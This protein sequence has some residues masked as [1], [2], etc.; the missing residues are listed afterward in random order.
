MVFQFS[1]FRRSLKFLSSDKQRSFF[2]S[3]KQRGWTKSWCW[4]MTNDWKLSWSN[5]FVIFLN[6]IFWWW[7]FLCHSLSNLQTVVKKTLYECYFAPEKTAFYTSIILYMVPNDHSRLQAWQSGKTTHEIFRCQKSNIESDSIYSYIQTVVGLRKKRKP[8]SEIQHRHFHSFN[9]H[10]GK[11]CCP[12]A[13][14]SIYPMNN[15]TDV[16]C[17][18]HWKSGGPPERAHASTIFVYLK[19]CE[20]IDGLVSMALKLL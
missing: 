7:L 3:E 5:A 17:H 6:L 12:L 15:P 19:V 13:Q 16:S 9:G 10:K 14:N 1:T 4:S 8:S 18:I 20:A 11:S 2:D